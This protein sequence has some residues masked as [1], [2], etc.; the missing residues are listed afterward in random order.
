MKGPAPDQLNLTSGMMVVGPWV[1]STLKS[2]SGSLNVQ[3]R[4]TDVWG[5]GGMG[6][7]WERNEDGE[8]T[9]V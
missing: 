8:R 7:G 3:L 2:F 4:T 9:E 5:D 6:V 1:T